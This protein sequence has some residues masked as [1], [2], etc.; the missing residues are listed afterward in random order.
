MEHDHRSRVWTLTAEIAGFGLAF[1]SGVAVSTTLD[2]PSW[3]KSVSW[4]ATALLFVLVTVSAI[5]RSRLQGPDGQAVDAARRAVRPGRKRRAEKA[6]RRAAREDGYTGLGELHEQVE[7][8]VRS[9]RQAAERL[10]RSVIAVSMAPRRYDL[11]ADVSLQMEIYDSLRSGIDPQY[12]VQ[13]ALLET[14]KRYTASELLNASPDALEH[15]LKSLPLGLG[16]AWN[17]ARAWGDVLKRQEALEE[18]GRLTGIIEV[19][20]DEVGAASPETKKLVHA[21]LVTSESLRRAVLDDISE[22]MPGRPDIQQPRCE[23]TL[24]GYREVRGD[25]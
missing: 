12:S 23:D 17:C 18:C 14:V 2:W 7:E 6:V 3:A 8:I 4:L 25:P 10:I 20:R 15:L 11:A 24:R 5:R 1:V 22:T 21:M 9:D 13:R 16:M 19:V